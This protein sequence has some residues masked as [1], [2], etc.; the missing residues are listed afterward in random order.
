MKNIN[1]RKLA[2][3]FIFIV[4]ICFPPIF[5]I[6]ILDFTMPF[7]RETDTRQHAFIELVLNEVEVGQGDWYY[8]RPL[9]HEAL[10]KIDSTLRKIDINRDCTFDLTLRRDGRASCIS[11]TAQSYSR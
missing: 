5:A 6:Y 9:S 1:I 2:K 4:H 10:D 3:V 7:V 11:M 8:R